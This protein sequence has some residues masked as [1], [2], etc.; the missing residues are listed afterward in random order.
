MTH[1]NPDPAEALAA[2]QRTQQEV[3]RKVAAGSWRYDLIYSAVVA[4][5]IGSQAL[6]MPLSAVGAMLGVVALS[7]MLRRESDRLGVMVTGISPKRA[8][9]VAGGL[10]AIMVAIMIGVIVLKHRGPD[11][12]PLTLG[13][14][15]LMA[16]AFA[17][18]LGA[19]RLWLRVYR[20]ETGVDQ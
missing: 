5:M 13:V 14:A 8:R 4:G 17:L 12:L 1:E 15:G 7:V 11:G 3:H 6:D 16:L 2:I 19:S 9:W 18:A 10:G 20:C